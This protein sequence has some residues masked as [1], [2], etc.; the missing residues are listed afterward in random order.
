MVGVWGDGDCD[1]WRR[2]AE[3]AQCGAG[4]LRGTMEIGMRQI[5]GAGEVPVDDEFRH[6]L[7]PYLEP[8]LI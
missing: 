7:S 5:S 3:V 8:K 6:R 2:R 1:A 4:A